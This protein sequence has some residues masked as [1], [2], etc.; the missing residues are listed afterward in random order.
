MEGGMNVA[1]FLWVD[2]ETLK[3]SRVLVKSCPYPSGGLP[4]DLLDSSL[5]QN[6]KSLSKIENNLSIGSS[7]HIQDT[8]PIGLSMVGKSTPFFRES[9]D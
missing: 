6:F 7:G 8:L 5:I 4:L 2:L 9:S 3:N 1:R